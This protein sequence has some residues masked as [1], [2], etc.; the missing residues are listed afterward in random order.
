MPTA[1]VVLLCLEVLDSWVCLQPGRNGDSMVIPLTSLAKV[2][3]GEPY[4]DNSLLQPLLPN[5]L[6]FHVSETLF[7]V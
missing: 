3:V 7:F 1:M 5:M 6:V 4:N 2:F